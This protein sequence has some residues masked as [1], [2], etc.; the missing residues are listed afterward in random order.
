MFDGILPGALIDRLIASG[1]ALFQQSHASVF[2]SCTS[3]A[4]LV[5]LREQ[6]SSMLLQRRLVITSRW[7][8]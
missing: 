8:R 2:S 6:K 4:A 1:P 7:I 3:A 5:R